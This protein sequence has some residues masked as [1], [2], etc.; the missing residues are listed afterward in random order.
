M[1]TLHPYEYAYVRVMPRIE[2]EEFFNTGV[3]L[4]CRTKRFLAAKIT[5]RPERLQ[6]I[7][8]YLNPD[9]VQEH[10]A[11]IPRICAGEGPIGTLELSE[12][13]RW[14]AAPHNAVVQCGPIHGGRCEEPGAVLERLFRE[15]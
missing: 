15:V 12:R 5:F 10:L 8:P 9:Q 7:A 1:P 11:L 13:F 6:S 3:I 2:R 14:I 4:F